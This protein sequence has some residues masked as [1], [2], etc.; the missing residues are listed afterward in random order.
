[1]VANKEIWE[2]I[3]THDVA[4]AVKLQGE[5]SARTAKELNEPLEALVELQ[6][7]MGD[8][9]SMEADERATWTQRGLWAVIAV[10][11]TAA[12]VLALLLTR[13]ITRPLRRLAEQAG[14]LRDAVAAGRLDVRGDPDLVGREF[15][16]IIAGMNETMDAYARPIAVTSQYVIAIARGES[17]PPI[18]ES[19]QGDFERI[20]ASLNELVEITGRRN[21]DIDALI[22]AALEGRLDY[23]ADPAG[24]QGDNARVI[25][26]M[27]RMLD[28]LVA[29]LRMA[30][31]HL[32]RIAR[33]D[34]PEKI[35]ADYQGD[36][37]HLK[38]SLN[39]CIGALGGVLHDMGE[40]TAAQAAGD[41]DTFMDEE[42]FQGAYR[43]LAAGVNAGVR[44]HVDVMRKILDM[45][46][47]YADGDFSPVLEKLPGKQALVS[48]RMNL[49]RT[50][51][52]SVADQIRAVAGAAVEGRLSA[53]ADASPFKGDWA[54]LVTRLNATLDALAAPVD[55]ATRVLERLA[56]RDLRARATGEYGGDHARI[57]DALNATAGALHDALAQVSTAVEQVSSAATQI[58]SS[59]HSVAGGASQQAASLQETTSAMEAV[60]GLTQQATEGARQANGLAQTARTAATEG[61]GA[62]KALQGAM[63]KIKEASAGTSQII[64]DVSDIAFQTNLLALNAAVEAARAGEAGRGFA[65]VAEE[66]RSLALR[67]KDAARKTEDLIRQS[68]A[69]AAAGEAAADRV[70][71]RLGEI[72]EGVSRVTSVVG[73]IAGVS[74]QQSAGIQR[75]KQAIVDMDRVTQQNAASAEES[76]S[77][78]SE[79]SS[80]SEEL[81]AMVAT[82]RLESGVALAAAPARARRGGSTADEVRAP[83]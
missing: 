71:G 64:R 8:R 53:R 39:T 73:E 29:P 37:D 44:V 82:F 72:V 4:T 60:A 41:I 11:L 21:A 62:V 63:L 10:T 19:Y 5:L 74:E 47:A 83:G 66:V 6:G 32:A 28:A 48:E 18:V 61:S 69:Q 35:A 14:V 12:A 80:Q 31:D 20:K 79:L 54:A 27:N 36:F 59:S 42:R 58:A 22:A 38:Q 46:S 67:A 25:E 78:A 52:R 49:L 7:K 15:R 17:P 9:I 2:A 33:G 50:N 16:P 57:K 70:A 30:A 76:S 75:V 40:M 65:V 3:R 26:G 56:D 13:T 23:R 51:L 55:E 77:A 81:A 34:I 68:V 1:M 24:Y 45:L 43:R